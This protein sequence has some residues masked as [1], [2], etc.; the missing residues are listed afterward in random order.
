M[1]SKNVGHVSRQ[2]PN[3][4]GNTKLN[5]DK[6]PR[7]KIRKFGDQGTGDHVTFTDYM[8]RG[9]VHGAKNAYV[10]Y[11]LGAK[12]LYMIPTSAINDVQTL[13]AMNHIYGEHPRKCYYSDNSKP[14]ENAATMAG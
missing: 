8:G 2:L 7:R 3:K 14:L 5:L 12:G 1:H 10:H 11:D 4:S 13:K 9:G 6:H